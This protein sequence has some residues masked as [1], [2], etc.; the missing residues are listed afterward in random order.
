M[1]SFNNV[2]VPNS[3]KFIKS[4]SGSPE[5]VYG[6]TLPSILETLNIPSNVKFEVLT[7]EVECE[8]L[9]SIFIT[10]DSRVTIKNDCIGKDQ[11]LLSNDEIDEIIDK[12]A[13][14]VCI[15]FGAK[16]N[17]NNL[18]SGFD[19]RSG[20]VNVNNVAAAVI[21]GA[22]VKCDKLYLT[23]IRSS[24]IVA[25]KANFINSCLTR[26]D[27]RT[28][29]HVNFFDYIDD[30]TPFNDLK[31]DLSKVNLIGSYTE[32]PDELEG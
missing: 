25:R 10:E 27:L 28:K 6:D 4:R 9:L 17:I 21:V 30:N 1:T 24:E 26:V 3:W 31:I 2:T 13:G 16:I 7:Y 20:D 8:L 5:S 15:A 11:A 18:Y 22:I 19:V 29:K 32:C 12:D 23:I 14:I